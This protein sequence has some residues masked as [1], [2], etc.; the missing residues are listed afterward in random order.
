LDK[1]IQDLPEI[2]RQTVNILHRIQNEY[3]YIPR[4][5]LTN[6]AAVTG[7]PESAQQG[8]ISFFNSYRTRPTGKHCISVCYGTACYARGAHLIYDRLSQD[9]DLDLDGNSPDGL[10]TVDKVFCVGACSQAPVIIEDDKLKGKVKSH[11]VPFLI[12]EL[13]NK[14]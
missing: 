4:L 8:L 13:R 7:I 12:R 6:L 3:G 10:V 11:Q 9:L 2:E 14:E 1:I 5:S